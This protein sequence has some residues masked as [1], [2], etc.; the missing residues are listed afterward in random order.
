MEK[1]STTGL[2]VVKHVF[3]VHCVDAQ[4]AVVV[5]RKLRPRM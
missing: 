3:Q 2:D 5:R 4:G 1:V